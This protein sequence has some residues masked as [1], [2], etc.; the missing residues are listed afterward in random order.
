MSLTRILWRHAWACARIGDASGCEMGYAAALCLVTRG[1][2]DPLKRD[3]WEPFCGHD[4][5]GRAGRRAWLTASV[6]SPVTVPQGGAL[7]SW[8]RGL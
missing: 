7:W 1:E 4:R 2:P 3:G 5:P 6:G 8:E